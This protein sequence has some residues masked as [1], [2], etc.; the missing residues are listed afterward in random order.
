MAVPALVNREMVEPRL[1]LDVVKWFSVATCPIPGC[2]SFQNCAPWSLEDSDTV[3][4]YVKHHLMHSSSKGHML[5]AEMADDIIQDEVVVDDA[6]WIL[7]DRVDWADTHGTD[8][9]PYGKAKRGRGA[10]GGG[11]GG[12][13]AG[14]DTEDGD[15]D[16]GGGGGGKKARTASPKR[17]KG[18]RGG[19]DASASSEVDKLVGAVASLTAT[20]TTQAQQANAVGGGGGG[21]GGVASAST[22]TLPA[23]DRQLIRITT[24]DDAKDTIRRVEGVIRNVIQQNVNCARALQAELETLADIRRCMI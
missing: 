13:G 15:G 22:V 23:T 24:S 17:R 7:E 11:G 5:S 20:L 8:P 2:Q 12:G 3:L 9:V 6:E 14:A 18:G 4:C 21:G 10:G 1:H 19:G 16:G